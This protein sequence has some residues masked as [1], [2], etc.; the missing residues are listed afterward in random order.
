MEET[1]CTRELT[2]FENALLTGAFY[3]T[4]RSYSVQKNMRKKRA[5]L[6]HVRHIPQRKVMYGNVCREQKYIALQI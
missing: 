5:Y 2:T 6:I 4:M 1:A 3:D